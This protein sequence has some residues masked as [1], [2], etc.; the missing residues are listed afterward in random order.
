MVTS[1]AWLSLVFVLETFTILENNILYLSSCLGRFCFTKDAT[2][3]QE[4]SCSGIFQLCCP[5]WS[6]PLPSAASVFSLSI[7]AV[8]VI[9]ASYFTHPVHVLNEKPVTGEQFMIRSNSHHRASFQTPL[10]Y[11][12]TFAALPTAFPIRFQKLIPLSNLI[13]RYFKSVFR[14]IL[15]LKLTL[16]LAKDICFVQWLFSKLRCEVYKQ[17]MNNLNKAFKNLEKIFLNPIQNL[18]GSSF[19]VSYISYSFGDPNSGHH[20]YITMLCLLF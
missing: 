9:R 10:C 17:S 13:P 18:V 14:Y 15:Q 5:V 7:L 2:Q 12:N 3:F 4:V 19:K 16:K 6:H 20:E 8:L 11:A 1:F